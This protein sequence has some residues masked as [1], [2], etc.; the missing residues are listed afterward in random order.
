MRGRDDGLLPMMLLLG[1][2][3]VCR[4]PVVHLGRVV[5][6]FMLLSTKSL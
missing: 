6:D 3:G 5:G 4:Q 1:E 2:S